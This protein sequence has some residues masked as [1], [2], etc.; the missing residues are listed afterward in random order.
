MLGNKSIL[1]LAT[2]CLCL[3]IIEISFQITLKT[4][5]F[6]DRITE[7]QNG[8]CTH[9]IYENLYHQ[10][11]EN[12]VEF[13]RD[14]NGFVKHQNFSDK[15][16]TIYVCG[17]ST[18][19]AMVVPS[20]KRW[21]AILEVLSRNKVVN[22]SASG[23]TFSECLQRLELYLV[24]SPKPQK[25]LLLNN[26][27]TLGKFAI[28][29]ATAKETNLN[30]NLKKKITYLYYS[31]FPGIANARRSGFF[32]DIMRRE[33]TVK[34]VDRSVKSNDPA[35]KIDYSYSIALD[36]NCCHYASMLNSPASLES[37]DWKSSNNVDDYVRFYEQEL[38]T[39]QKTLDKFDIP[40][41]NILFGFE[42]YSYDLGKSQFGDPMRRQPLYNSDFAA[43]SLSHR[44]SHLVVSRFDTAI[45]SLLVSRKWNY[46]DSQEFLTRPEYFYDTVHLTPL[47]SEKMAQGV[48]QIIK[49][50]I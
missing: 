6:K 38:N 19:E 12:L 10:S 4:G 43:K 16:S 22:D 20:G 7:T 33:S 39:L 13:C 34:T 15:H 32:Q 48:F 47:G 40:R 24:K 23:R 36:S 1:L 11:E 29:N 14:S 37:F 18:T 45:R 17:G 42:S 27:N 25:I 50:N 41:D 21:P 46:F 26:V 9:T 31:M 5:F 28:D 2:I 3:I 44:E 35:F 49:S 8:N 30:E